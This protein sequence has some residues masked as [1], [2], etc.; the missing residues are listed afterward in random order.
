MISAD[1]LARLAAL[2]LPPE[3]LQEVLAIFA[4]HARV[5]EARRQRDRDRKR[6]S[7]MSADSHSDSHTKKGLPQTP[8]KETIGLSK[9]DKPIDRTRVRARVSGVPPEVPLI[10]AVEFA[11]GQGWTPERIATEWSRFRDWHLAHG[12]QRKDVMAAWRNWCRSPYQQEVTA[13]QGTLPLSREEA[14]AP[15]PHIQNFARSW[16]ARSRAQLSER[17]REVKKWR[18]PQGDVP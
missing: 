6:K 14:L 7:R 4:D 17:E 2:K 3:T 1:T 5:D 11:T 18:K 13:R 12:K 8:S 9:S 10:A 15:S 16:E